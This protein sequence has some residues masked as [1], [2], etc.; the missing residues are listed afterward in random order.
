MPNQNDAIRRKNAHRIAFDYLERQVA[1]MPAFASAEKF[2][3][4]ACAEVVELG[5]QHDDE[6]T[7]QLLITEYFEL[8]RIWRAERSGD[9]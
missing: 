7:R 3:Q 9:T 1:K 6:L 4:Q 8:E 2:W 5:N